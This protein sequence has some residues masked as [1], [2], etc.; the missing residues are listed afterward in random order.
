MAGHQTTIVILNCPAHSTDLLC[1]AK[2]S[3]SA[4]RTTLS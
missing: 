1:V 3:R 4:F 2:L